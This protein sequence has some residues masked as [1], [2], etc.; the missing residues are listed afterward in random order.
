MNGRP[1]DGCGIE[2][3]VLAQERPIDTQPRIEA[4]TSAR[5]LQRAVADRATADRAITVR[6]IGLEQRRATRVDE[7]YVSEATRLIVARAHANAA[8]CKG[9]VL[10]CVN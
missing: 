5:N 4:I 7:R 2:R 9:R 10:E 8:T 3:E 6:K 1:R